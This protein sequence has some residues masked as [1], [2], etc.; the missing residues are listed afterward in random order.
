M[1]YVPKKLKFLNAAD[2]E[3][4]IDEISHKAAEHH[5]RVALLG[6]AAM[7]L[8]GSDRLTVDVDFVA[9]DTLPIV[10][11]E[12]LRF[13]G[14]AGKT[15]GGVPVDLLIREDEATELYEAALSSAQR[16]E[17]VL[18]PVVTP[19]FL[20][21]MKLAAGRTKDR[22]DLLYLLMSGEANADATRKIAYRF[23]G[24]YGADDFD[25]YVAEAEVE[26]ARSKKHGSKR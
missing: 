21:V 10:D 14:I 18:V 7:Q 8:Y 19:E 26:L 13:G 1:P 23:L 20:A 25:S 2:I 4:A 5:V 15:E 3:S 9:E 16:M 12:P 22:Q 24:Y 11:P 6:G 17:G